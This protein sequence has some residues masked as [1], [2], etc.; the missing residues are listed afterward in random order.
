MEDRDEAALNVCCERLLRND[1]PTLVDVCVP[2]F[3]PQYLSTCSNYLPK[4]TTVTCIVF[5]VTVHDNT[6]CNLDLMLEYLSQTKLLQSVELNSK[7]RRTSNANEIAG[8]L[9]R[10]IADNADIELVHFSSLWVPLQARDHHLLDLLHKKASS[11]RH[12]KLQLRCDK[13][14]PWSEHDV[15]ALA[16]AVGGLSR[17]QSLTLEAFPNPEL[18]AL[19]ICQL[20]SHKHLQKLS[21]HGYDSEWSYSGTERADDVA[22]V[23]AVSVMLKSHVPLE[24][25]E[26]RN[27][28]CSQTCME[29]LLQGLE[30]C[31]SLLE[32]ALEGSLLGEA[33]GALVRFLR[34][35]K[36]AAA[37]NIRRL[38][39]RDLN[40][41]SYLF[42][43]VLTTNDDGALRSTTRTSIGASLRALSL[44]YC[45]ANIDVL[46][47]VLLAGAHHLS[48]LSL[49][50]LTFTCWTRLISRLPDLVHLHELHFNLDH[51]RQRDVPLRT[52]CT[53][54]E[55]MVACVE[56]LKFIS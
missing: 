30:S 34:A 36:R 37:N 2:I 5:D 17:L 48:R 28:S 41:T 8:R 6:G 19:T 4:S 40:G 24:I 53:P 42:Q 55:T 7:N 14:P 50:L 54:C 20:S 52:L 1:D 43:H 12:L 32:L 51:R 33:E 46:L 23:N 27:V 25:L 26:L 13:S 49:G 9:I 22:I 35:G 11:L 44:P 21:I 15:M 39:L 18:S 29:S 10:A 45:V 31:S 3:R 16:E 47:N 56:F 38:R